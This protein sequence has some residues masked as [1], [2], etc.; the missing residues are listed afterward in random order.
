MEWN[1]SKK[2]H[3]FSMQR[4]DELG[5]KSL[6]MG[7]NRLRWYILCVFR[8]YLELL[9]HKHMYMKHLLSHACWNVSVSAVPVALQPDDDS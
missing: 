5:T 2:H 9:V 4:R 3:V 8:L 6:E 7:P 1:L